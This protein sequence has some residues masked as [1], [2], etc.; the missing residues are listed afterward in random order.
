MLLSVASIWAVTAALVLSALQRL[1][2]GDYDVNGEIMLITS[3]CAVGVNI[4]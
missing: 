2:H 3:A 4:L 1:V